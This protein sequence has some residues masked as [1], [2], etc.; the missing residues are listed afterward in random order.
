NDPTS[1]DFLINFTGKYFGVNGFKSTIVENTVSGDPYDLYEPNND[2]S[3]TALIP[4]YNYTLS[5]TIGVSRDVD[6]YAQYFE[7][8][9]EIRI[10]LTAI[11]TNC[12]YDL[13]LCTLDLIILASSKNNGNLSELIQGSLNVAGY[14]IV[15]VVPRTTADFNATAQYKLYTGNAPVSMLITNYQGTPGYMETAPG[16]FTD[17]IKPVNNN[18][19]Y[20]NIP[21]NAI[22]IHFTCNLGA[23][24]AGPD[25]IYLALT[26]KTHLKCGIKIIEKQFDE[27]PLS[28]WWFTL[29][30][31]D[32][33]MPSG[34]EY[35]V[36]V[37]MSYIN[38]RD[39][40][41]NANYMWITDATISYDWK[42]IPAFKPTPYPTATPTPRP[43]ITP[44]IGSTV[45][46]TMMAT[47]T[48][49]PIN[50]PPVLEPIGNKIVPEGQ[51]LQFSIHATDPDEDTLTYSASDLPLGAT[52][53]PIARVFRWIPDY[54]I[55][56]KFNPEVQFKVLFT[57]NDGRGGQ[58]S[59]DVTIIVTDVNRP[60]IFDPINNKTIA[61]GEW[62]QFPI[63]ATDPDGD[64][65]T[66]SVTNLPFGATFDPVS[67][68]F[69]WI[70]NFNQAGSPNPQVTFIVADGRGG[71]DSETVI[72]TITDAAPVELLP[73][74]SFDNGTDS[75]WCIPD[76]TM[77]AFAN[78]IWDT[79]DYDTAPGSLKTQCISQGMSYKDIQLFTNRFNL[80]KDKTYLLTF[81]AKSSNNFTIPS[82][83]L[84]QA[85][86]PWNDYAAPYNSLP[87]TTGWQNY[88]AIFT[89]NTAVS[90]GRL[91]FFL[92]NA[93]PAGAT[94][95]IDSLSLKQIVVYPPSANELLPN[96]DFNFGAGNWCLFTDTTAQANGALDAAAF[97]SAPVSYRI[98]CLN[99]GDTQSSLQLFT[100]PINI[101]QN[102]TYRLT[103][104]AKSTGIFAIP[105]IQ[106]MKATSPWTLYSNPYSGLTITNEW[107][108]YSIIFTA[109]TTTTDGRITFFLGNALPDGATFW[110]DSLS[111]REMAQ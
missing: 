4:F 105:S 12:N 79:S 29:G 93:L 82:I 48:P 71:E 24:G 30:N 88:A 17:P 77:N 68:N 46:P 60:P 100:M 86:I 42:T 78:A 1:S 18:S 52:F 15:V 54:N 45:T 102:K 107:Q 36:E 65:L 38:E 57:V 41:T 106:F 109:N 28:Q 96:P 33:L 5:A 98:Q 69:R 76:K 6:Y 61:E 8:G 91:T 58:A 31:I 7:A 90:D 21:A 16:V 34:I 81:K 19:L 53:D 83:K 11:P 2:P 23:R 32:Q 94:F 64:P 80:E 49:T 70:P 75:W 59:K 50:H 55:A 99:N 3:S 103:F 43:T 62:L 66:Y 110:I 89:A 63:I 9:K 44:T 27:L 85:G 37:D 97:D 20:Y 92:G 67:R 84:N 87:V 101:V 56:N 35:D 13:Y 22:N 47:A 25:T 73:N 104:R 40:F 14:C 51:L 39:F 74:P 26:D 10:L 95:H 111:L 108:T 72:I